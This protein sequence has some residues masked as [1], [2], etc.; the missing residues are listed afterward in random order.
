MVDS[1]QNVE[2]V[3]LHQVFKKI[4]SCEDSNNE[5]FC[6]FHSIF[7]NHSEK[8]RLRLWHQYLLQRKLIYT[9]MN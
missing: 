3:K 6:D 9:G 4:N 1:E 5:N 7:A 2:K 8:E